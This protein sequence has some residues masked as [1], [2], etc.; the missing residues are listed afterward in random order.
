MTEGL[1]KPILN[2]CILEFGIAATK[3]ICQGKIINELLYEP[4]P[5]LSNTPDIIMRQ[6]HRVHTGFGSC[7][8]I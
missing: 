2:V 1:R 3:E 5:L 7:D 8:A 4:Y 6:G